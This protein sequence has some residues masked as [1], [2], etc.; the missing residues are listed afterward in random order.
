[1]HFDPIVAFVGIPGIGLI[2]V[3]YLI[4]KVVQNRRRP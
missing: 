3:E 4:L 1:M 2:L